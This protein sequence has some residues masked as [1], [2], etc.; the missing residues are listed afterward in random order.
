[1]TKKLKR[2]YFADK[3]KKTELASTASLDDHG[4]QVMIILKALGGL[5]FTGVMMTDESRFDDFAI[6]ASEFTKLSELL[7]IALD[8]DNEDDWWVAKVAARLKQAAI[9]TNN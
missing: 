1:M 3:I 9:S 7:G 4:P 2:G 5:G 8:P 6:D